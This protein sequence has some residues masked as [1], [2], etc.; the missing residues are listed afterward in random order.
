MDSLGLEILTVV[1]IT[2]VHVW[3]TALVSVRWG[4]R[5]LGHTDVIVA[6]M[7]VHVYLEEKYIMFSHNV[8]T[9]P[10][11]CTASYLRIRDTA[12]V[13]KCGKYQFHMK[14]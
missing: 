7:T 9:Y 3:I 10:P 11:N 6:V 14:D 8:G 5:F 1:C 2:V 4:P 12:S 13:H